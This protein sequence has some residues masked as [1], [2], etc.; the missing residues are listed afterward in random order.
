MPSGV[1]G[2]SMTLERG[3]IIGYDTERMTFEF[4]M[5]DAQGKI[6]HCKIS[7]TAMDELA[8]FK[9]TRPSEREAQFV[10]LRDTIERI[11]SDLFEEVVPGPIGLICIFHHHTR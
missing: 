11:A 9:G 7:S 5:S 10:K 1:G 4:T 3:Q 2:L 8:G 6:V